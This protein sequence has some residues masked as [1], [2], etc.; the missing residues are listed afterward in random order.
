ML[1]T[2]SCFLSLVFA[3]VLLF[4][5][6]WGILAAGSLV[7]RAESLLQCA[8]KATVGVRMLKGS[9]HTD[10]PVYAFSSSTAQQKPAALAVSG[11][12]TITDNSESEGV[13]IVASTHWDRSAVCTLRFNNGE[14]LLESG[15]MNA[16]SGLYTSYRSMRL[17]EDD[18]KELAPSL[19]N[20]FPEIPERVYSV[21]E[22]LVPEGIEVTAIGL[23]SPIAED[24]QAATQGRPRFRMT[25]SANGPLALFVNSPN[26]I[27]SE[28]KQ[29]RFLAALA[30][31][32]LGLYGAVTL[33]LLLLS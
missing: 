23:L 20:S 11:S 21:S 8:A 9:L 19:A 27:I 30:A 12:L 22:H 17:S 24:P 1:A 13:K 31:G 3:L 7:H 33:L 26:E 15:G 28:H 5:R 14:A 25:G 2:L 18:L 16:F 4:K 29:R 6:P 10:S 32:V